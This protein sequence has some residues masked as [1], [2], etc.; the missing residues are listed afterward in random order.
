M[1][2]DQ[3]FKLQM[4]LK[5]LILI[6]ILRAVV[7]YK[8]VYFQVTAQYLVLFLHV[9]AT[10]RSHPQGAAVFDNI[11]SVLCNLAVLNDKLYT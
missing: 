11:C 9:S 10:K 3:N 4:R 8:R 6:Y 2:S 7:L 5:T 1:N